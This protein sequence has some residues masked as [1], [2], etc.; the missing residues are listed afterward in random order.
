MKK[1]YEYLAFLDSENVIY[2]ASSN[3][4]NNWA[5]THR[6]EIE[7]CLA[8]MELWKK[9]PGSKLDMFSKWARDCIAFTDE[10][11]RVVAV[12]TLKEI[13]EIKQYVVERE[14][15]DAIS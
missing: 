2:R 3:N 12:L 15:V 10:G 14:K 9:T 11:C 6:I 4:F 8:F 13:E 7:D 5:Y 1:F